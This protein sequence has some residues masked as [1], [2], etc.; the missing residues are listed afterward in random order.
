[1]SYHPDHPRVKHFRENFMDK[2]VKEVCALTG[3]SASS[4]YVL[5]NAAGITKPWYE[6][7]SEERNREGERFCP[8]CQEWHSIDNFR[9]HALSPGGRSS[10][11]RKCDRLQKRRAHLKRTYNLTPEE[12]EQLLEHGDG[13]AIC[14]GPGPLVV[15]HD[16]TTG[17]VRGLLCHRCNLGIGHFEDLPERLMNA[18]AY[19]NASKQDHMR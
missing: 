1:M 12:V 11:C 6:K 3:L 2:S 10:F 8:K 15:D 19:I 13:C 18:V 4:V 16:H 9:V 7:Q 17:K 14:R 5:R